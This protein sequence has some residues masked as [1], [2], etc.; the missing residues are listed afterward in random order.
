MLLFVMVRVP[1][2]LMAPSGPILLVMILL[3]SVSS[4]A[5]SMK[6]LCSG[7]LFLKAKPEKGYGSPREHMDTVPKVSTANGEGT[8]SWAANTQ[9]F[10][11]IEIFGSQHNR[12]SQSRGKG[13]GASCACNINSLAQRTWAIIIEVGNIGGIRRTEQEQKQLQR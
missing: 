11:D 1:L 3:V 5:L 2:L 9:V 13:D 8:S 12:P 7:S 10:A 4:P 6:L